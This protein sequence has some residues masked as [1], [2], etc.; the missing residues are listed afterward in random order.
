MKKLYPIVPAFAA[1]FLLFAL[2]GCSSC[3]EKEKPKEEIASPQNIGMAP[4]AKPK[5]D[6]KI[7]GPTPPKPNKI[8][9]SAAHVLITHD[10]SRRKPPS[11][12]RTKAEALAMAKEVYQKVKAG[13]DFA[14]MAKE[15]S[16][17]PTKEKGGDL[18]IFLAQ[19]MV[20]A[21]SEA[22]KALEVGEI[23]EPIE[24]VFGYHIIK[25]QKVEQIHARHILVMHKESK[26]KGPVVDRTKE[27]AEAIA[28]EVA[29]K[30]KKTDADFAML[31][32][33]Y[34]D[35]PTKNKGGELPKFFPGKMYPR[36]EKAAA[37]MKENEISDIVETAFGFHIIQ[38]LPLE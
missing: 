24:T 12:N 11:V 32:K 6:V 23:S 37:A 36:F 33:E 35:C 29:K 4:A 26:R 28:Q 20:P 2:S 19:K 5:S 10:Q 15:Y 16:E 27:E 8:R 14:K 21:F 30:L 34:S 22:T 3:S 18:G 17:G 31:A 38:R 9:L 25:R 1:A 13:A 7:P